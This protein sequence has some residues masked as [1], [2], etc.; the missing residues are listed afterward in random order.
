MKPLHSKRKL[1]FLLTLLKKILRF[2]IY[3]SYLLKLFVSSLFALPED[4]SDHKQAVNTGQRAAMCPCP[5]AGCKYIFRTLAAIR[6]PLGEPRPP[7]HTP[8]VGEGEKTRHFKQKEAQTF[9]HPKRSISLC[10]AH[11]LFL[12]SHSR[13]WMRT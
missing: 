7:P 11:N 4:T 6:S 3:L 1:Y 2:Y 13:W 10:P 8:A 12:C 5:V 9:F